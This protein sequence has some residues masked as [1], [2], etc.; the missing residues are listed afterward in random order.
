MRS[1]LAIGI[2]AALGL[3]GA[4]PPAS[5]DW[6]VTRDGGRVETRG[7]WEVKGRLVLFH[8]ANAADAGG[9]SLASIRAADVDFEASRKA[10]EDAQKAAASPASPVRVLQKKS[11][12][13]FT[14]KD[15]RPAVP[16]AA[17]PP[18]G[19]PEGAPE[20]AAAAQAAAKQEG[21]PAADAPVKAIQVSTW[22]RTNDPDA[23]YVVITGVVRNVSQASAT[24]VKLAVLLEDENGSLLLSSQASVTA[25]VLMPGEQAGFRAK[26]WSA[27]RTAAGHSRYAKCPQS[28]S[29]IRRACG[30]AWATYSEISLGMKS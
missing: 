18:E 14:D 1:K 8:S 4:L 23:G 21:K 28:S 24:N 17:A 22:D 30:R 2:G 27:V 16:P 5:A 15:F 10:T 12:R 9:G 29:V 25:S 3:L 26:S 13:S 20:A 6:L 7:S 11:V 19:S